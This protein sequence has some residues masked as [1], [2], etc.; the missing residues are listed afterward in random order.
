MLTPGY[1]AQVGRASYNGFWR[2]IRSVD[3]SDVVPAGGNSV[4]AT[5]TYTSNSG[6]TS[7]E[8]HRLDL[9]PSGDG[10]LING[11]SQA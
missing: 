9:V 3:V 4:L 6:S 11:D 2:T 10:Y 7:V 1:Q 8:R 5:L